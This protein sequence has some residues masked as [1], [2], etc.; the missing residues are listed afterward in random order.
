MLRDFYFFFQEKEPERVCHR[1][2]SAVQ[3]KG[4]K[5]ILFLCRNTKRNKGDKSSLGTEVP[6][7]LAALLECAQGLEDGVGKEG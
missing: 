5:R 6:V 3:I 1:Q 7:A 2:R 4:L